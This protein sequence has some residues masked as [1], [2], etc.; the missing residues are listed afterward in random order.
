M[1]GSAGFTFA[2]PAHPPLPLS[3]LGQQEVITIARFAP[4]LPGNWHT[5]RFEDE[6][7]A[8]GVM[9]T[10]DWNEDFV[11]VVFRQGSF[12]SFATLVGDDY[13]FIAAAETVEALFQTMA[14]VVESRRKT[15]VAVGENLN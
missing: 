15:L 3:G 13:E 11:L 4:T 1:A 8:A 5:E 6:F 7:A 9:L 10:S 12:V 2:A 14:G